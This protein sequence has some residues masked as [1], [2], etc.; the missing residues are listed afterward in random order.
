MR[1]T[2]HPER[3]RDGIPQALSLRLQRVQ[4]SL[5]EHA[6]KGDVEGGGVVVTCDKYAAGWLRQGKGPFLGECP[7]NDVSFFRCH[8]PCQADFALH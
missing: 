5:A 3:C 7:C 2:L 6:N 1:S 8:V 4:A